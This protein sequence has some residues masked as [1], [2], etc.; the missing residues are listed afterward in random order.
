MEDA[1]DDAPPESHWAKNW[2][3]ST[4]LSACFILGVGFLLGEGDGNEVCEF[5]KLGVCWVDCGSQFVVS[6]EPYVSNR[7]QLCFST[8][9]HGGVFAA[10]HGEEVSG[11]CEVCDTG[12][13]RG[14]VDVAMDSRGVLPHEAKVSG[15]YRFLSFLVGV[16]LGPCFL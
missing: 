12:F 13:K 8:L 10:A 16:Y 14:E 1:P 2:V 7:Q 5:V 11:E 4:A 3:G 15:C 9:F 6:F